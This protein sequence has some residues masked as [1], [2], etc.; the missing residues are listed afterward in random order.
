[1]N[2]GF[3]GIASEFATPSSR[4][5]S[6]CFP[7]PAVVVITIC[8]ESSSM[9]VVPMPLRTS[10]C[11]TRRPPNL[12][13]RHELG[14]KLEDGV[15]RW[16]LFKGRLGSEPMNIEPKQNQAIRDEIGEMLRVLLSREPSAP[17]PRLHK[18]LRRFD[19]VDYGS[20]SIV[21]DVLPGLVKSWLSRFSRP[22]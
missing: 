8:D 6:N 19:E 22:S 21:P 2:N 9:V 12:R 20:P 11:G 13:V 1:M 10:S 14:A 5:A 7:S 3:H 17:S 18:L 15:K 4:A 16:L